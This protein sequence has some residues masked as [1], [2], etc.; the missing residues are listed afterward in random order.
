MKI[1]CKLALV[2][3]GFSPFS[4]WA[5]THYV[6]QSS[7]GP[8]PPF[9]TWATAAATIQQAVD[10]AVAGD[11]IV[12][13]NGTYATG[14][15][16]VYSTYTDTMMTN[17]VAVDKPLALRSV[18][19]PQATV[20]D[21]GSAVGCV[22][23]TNGATLFG[24]T[25]TNGYAWNGGGVYCESTS[26]VLSNCVLTGNSANG[27]YDY[28]SGYHVGG[29]GG[30][31]YGGTMKNCTLTGNSANGYY[32]SYGDY[33]GIGGGAYNCTLNECMLTGN[34]AW[35]G[36]G[37]AD[38]TLNN[39]ALT[40]NTANGYYDTFG[41]YSGGVGGGAYSDSSQP[42]TLNNCTLTGNSANGYYD[43]Y[44]DYVPGV[45]GGAFGCTLNNCIVYF[46]VDPNGG[47]YDPSST[48]NYRCTTPM[49]TNGVGNISADP[50]L[51]S[52]SHLSAG[53]PCIGAGSA[54]YAS[55][56]DIDGEAWA[57]PPSI[58]CDEYH[59]G[60]VTGPLTVAITAHYANV[61]TGFPVSL[62]VLIE[63][64]TELSVW[65]F[66]DGFVEVNQPYTS[67]TWTAPGEYLVTLWAF[68]DSYPGGVSA[69]VTVRV[70]DH[71][72]QYVALG[73]TNPV[74]PYTS[75][76]TAATNIQDAV[77][78]WIGGQLVLV[79]NGVYQ[80]GVAVT[81]PVT[82]ES[83]NGPDVTV[84]NGLGAARCLYLTN[85]AVLV[86]FTLTNGYAGNG[87]GVY[88][89]SASAVLL[90][91]VVS[92]NTATSVGGGAYGGTLNNCTL[93]GNT[94]SGH[95]GPRGI[96]G[97]SPYYVSG[98]GGGAYNCTLNN[99]TLLGNSANSGG[100]AAYSTLYNCALTANTANGYYE[101][102]CCD[103]Q[104]AP[105]NPDSLP[106][107][108]NG[109]HIVIV[110]YDD[111]YAGGVGGGAY[112]CTLNDCTLT[113]NLA[114]SG[115]GAVDSTLNNCAL[116]ANTANGYYDSG[117]Y[118]GGVGGGAYSDSSQ[119][120]TLNNCRLTGNS[121]SDDGGGA[122]SCTLNSCIVYFN[123]DPNGGN[124]DISSTL[125]YCCTMPMPPNGVGNISADPQLASA[126]HLSAESPC[127]GAGSATYIS[128][129]DIDG[130]A[131]ANPPSIG[132]DE[133][134]AGAVTGPLTVNL[135]ATFT[136]VATGFP[137]GLT[138][139]IEGRTDLS[140]WEFGDG[141]VEVNQPY[142]SH[143]WTAP[144]DYLV[145]LWAYN[146]SYPGGVS[147]TLTIHVEEG[148]HYV[149]A[150]SGNPIAPYTSWATAAT[151]IQDAVDV[152]AP[153]ATVFVTNGTY[154][155]GG[156]TTPSPGDGV[157]NRVAVDKPLTVRSV[158]GPGVTVIQG[159]LPGATN[160]NIRCVYLT[161]A[162]T[163]V[164]FT[165]TNGVASDGYGGG[166]YCESTSAV[167]SNCVLTGNSANWSGGGAY[168]GTLN[169]CTL[170][171]NSAT[172]GGGAQGGTLNNCTLTGN[173]TSGLGSDG[174]GADLS[175]LNN[176]TL[177]GNST[178]GYAGG[179]GWCTLNNC[180]LTGNSAT[181]GGGAMWSTLN[182]SVVY[183][184][185]ATQG[186]NYYQQYLGVLTYCCTTPMP[187]NGVGNITNAPLFVDQAN[188]NLRLQSNSPCINAGNNAYVVGS[189]DLDGNPRIVGGTV[190]IGAYEYQT[191]TS[192]ISYAWLQQYGLPTDGSA[193]HAD[194]DGTGMNVYQDWV[195]GLNPTNALSVLK[196]TSATK[197]NNPAGL[198]VT[199]QSMNTRMYYLQSSTNLAAQPAFSTIQSN[200]V[201]QAGTTSYMDT[202]ATN[203]GPYYYRVGVGN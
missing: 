52:A 203:A 53:S 127:R 7:P 18:D 112:N 187:T 139:F 79:S 50:Q 125:N 117:N 14:S 169:N 191:P 183:F 192:V 195:A 103:C 198:V 81:K 119:P 54:R 32:D 154:A 149:A 168:G 142:A 111:D 107:T 156:R 65:D 92:G 87:G 76:A 179:A 70:M 194:L 22:Y 123:T 10:A 42:C 6:W 44:G 98:A 162:A 158:N 193:D 173:S 16:V 146:E 201:G 37:A 131:W 182:N 5:A 67:H 51:A 59:A 60:A 1:Q 34:S 72:V 143:I 95:W 164:G 138:A 66:G 100:G 43:F 68:N 49:P 166:V 126:S 106:N 105:D 174:G 84:I 101:C 151:N 172:Y 38:S 197:T 2:L 82:V 71:P 108:A 56:T 121:A 63:G 200:I 94:A 39:C 69:T 190:D 27:Y 160:G 99:C 186:A 36:G 96:F 19:G 150:T 35:S 28:D 155:A 23:L 33:S 41:D 177:T 161:N 133:Y 58:G 61:A 199:W 55:G 73:S 46:N 104:V 9:L 157:T 188:G 137:V 196:M 202:T 91:C 48:L 102:S 80:A 8:A 165:L 170:T 189:T 31:A 110:D 184:N 124:Y 118:S 175:T 97:G 116:A 88:C 90:N 178:S 45:G 145:A 109:Q 128:G 64:R 115:G 140:L 17:R 114:N 176:C 134:H 21:G 147:A 24:F 78:A 136:N 4:V 122:Y 144:G 83:V 85:D 113:D 141:F 12:V 75:W 120:C 153:G 185:T 163:L 180:T 152:A 15:R 181:Y 167:L 25:L 148:L 62:T 93:T 86:G 3:C 40:G 89:E 130:E 20:I 135:T 132:C 159:Q 11:E 129:P 29:Y 30:G 57:N 74:A 13:T 171:G 47:N 26:A 77:D